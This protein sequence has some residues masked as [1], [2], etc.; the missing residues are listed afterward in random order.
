MSIEATIFS[1]MQALVPTW[2]T[3]APAGTPTPYA[4]FQLVGGADVSGYEADGTGAKFGRWQ[5]D[6]WGADYG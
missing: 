4:T 6:C 3:V 2:P 1:T 5:I